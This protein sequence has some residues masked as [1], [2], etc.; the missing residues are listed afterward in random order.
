MTSEDVYRMWGSNNEAFINLKSMKSILYQG[1]RGQVWVVSVLVES[2]MKVVR[3][4]F[5]FIVLIELE[6]YSA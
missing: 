3:F 6:K 5:H 2:Y 4:Y 1:V